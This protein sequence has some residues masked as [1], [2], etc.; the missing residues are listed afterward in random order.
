MVQVIFVYPECRDDRERAVEV[1][2]PIEWLQEFDGAYHGLK[3]AEDELC[4]QW[5]YSKPD[6]FNGTKRMQFLGR[7]KPESEEEKAEVEQT[8]EEIKRAVE[9]LKE[10][11][12]YPRV[13]TGCI[14][15]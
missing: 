13:V 9:Y 12:T 1:Y 14:I 3:V 7:H 8:K 2:L 6:A 10:R 4:S 5:G 15:E 11:K